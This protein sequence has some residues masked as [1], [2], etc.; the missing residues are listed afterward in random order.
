MVP[1]SDAVDLQRPDDDRKVALL[2]QQAKRGSPNQTVHSK[3]QAH[4]GAAKSS[5]TSRLTFS[6][7]CHK[8]GLG[9]RN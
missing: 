1:G 9:M 8:T 4:F 3:S 7:I 5:R 6:P 2:L